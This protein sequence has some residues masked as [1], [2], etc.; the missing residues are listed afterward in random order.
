MPDENQKFE[1][2]DSRISGKGLFATSLIKAN[3]VVVSWHP[4]V[5]SREQADALPK[6]EQHYLYPDGDDVLYMQAPE[7]YMNHSCEPNT[8]VVGKSD[9]A[10]R[11]IEPGE[12]IT[13][14]YMDLE[15]ENFVC[16]C[17]SQNCRSR[18]K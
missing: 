14:D 3:E 16:Q 17:G 8:Q 7:R 11:D 15:T 4:K 2:R 5:L 13:S 9:V 6:S 10:I 12:E 18:V 1:V